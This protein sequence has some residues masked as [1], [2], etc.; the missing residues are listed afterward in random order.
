M[1]SPTSAASSSV[2]P[3]ASAALLPS[4]SSPFF[5]FSGL[6]KLSKILRNAPLLARSPIKPSSSFNSTLKLS[7]STD[8]SRDAPCLP[9]PAVFNHIS[10][11]IPSLPIIGKRDNKLARLLVSREGRRGPLKGR[12]RQQMGRNLR[13]FGPLFLDSGPSA[14]ISPPTRRGRFLA[15]VYFCAGFLP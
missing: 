14:T 7:T 12:Q 6:R 13:H 1:S 2:L 3:I 4:G 10:S 9:R 11:A 15:P 8:G 5:F